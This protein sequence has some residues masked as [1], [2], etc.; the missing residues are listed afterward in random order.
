[1][2]KTHWFLTLSLGFFLSMGTATKAE[3]DDMGKLKKVFS[4]IMSYHNQYTQEKVY[5][6]L[7][8][9]GY[10]PGETIWFKA[11]VVGAGSLLPTDMSKVLYVE[12]LTPDGEVLKR[13]KYAILNGRTCGEFH[14]NNIIHTGYYEVRA[15]TR[16][17]LNWDPAYVFSRVI[18]VFNP[19]KE[20]LSYGKL[21]MYEPRDENDRAFKRPA[22]T[23]LR[24]TATQSADKVLMTFYPE[25]GYITQGVASRVAFKVTDKGGNP[26]STKVSLRR[27][28]DTEV[29]TTETVHEGMGV[30]NVPA[31]W[32]GG[33][34]LVEN[35]S[36][37]QVKFRLPA[38]RQTG[39]DIS[40]MVNENGDLVIKGKSNASFTSQT[41]GISVVC[42]GIACYFDTLQMAPSAAFEKKV[43]YKQLRG[44]IQQV[45][46]F[47]PQG[48][49]LSERL[50]WIEPHKAPM[51]FVVAQNASTYEPFSPI[52]LDF[53][54]KDAQGHP[55]QGEFS[56]AV[57]DIEGE[58]GADGT[59]INTELLL[60]SDLK[61]YIHKPEYYFE[62]NDE[63]HRQALDLLMMVQGWRRYAWKEMSGVEPFVLKQPVEDGL[64]VDGRIV[65][66]SSK[67]KGKEGMDVNLMIMLGGT[68]V[69]G[70]TKSAAD[71]SFALL[72]PDFYGDGVAYFTA[73]VNDKR[74]SCNVAL[75]RG[76]SPAP[77]PYHP[78]AM[79]TDLPTYK[80][81]LARIEPE[82]FQWTDTLPKI[83]HLP[84]ASVKEKQLFHP[85]GSRF[86]WMG[87][88]EAGKRRASLYYNI[89][90]ALDK[91]LDSGEQEMS[92]WDWLAKV[93]P[94]LTVEIPTITPK[95]S[96][97]GGD[98]NPDLTNTHPDPNDYL[99][100]N[101]ILWYR[102]C[103]VKVLLDNTRPIGDI[104]FMMSDVRSL[105][106]CED[107]NTYKN[108]T[109]DMSFSDDGR[110]FV[111]IL[112]YSRVDRGL[113]KDRKG[114]RVTVIHGYSK[115]EEFY[116]PDY[117]TADSPS[118][119][120][121][122][123]TLYWNPNVTTDKNGKAHVILFSNSR[124]NQHIRVNAQGMA[125][126]GQMFS[127]K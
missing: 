108:L 8:N 7:D 120:D 41:L 97:P 1:M 49:I 82:L 24:E 93:N 4:N 87:G 35:T 71:G 72:A 76:F 114:Q 92:L 66:N 31:D 42:R 124:P 44:G 13:N 34:A 11:Y 21:T 58:L 3:V 121:V 64:L 94:H 80:N 109:G 5:L 85:W 78:L 26:L 117:R 16:A 32:N 48:E 29:C 118:P 2:K 56:L 77:S 27:D 95:T 70:D 122:R 99:I 65:D 69:S 112:L 73:T 102:G 106:I 15:Y 6:H 60:C 79:K 12:L 125:I 68:F 63:T 30:L 116:N 39:C 45:T 51:E 14:L 115:Y 111:T 90:D 57:H 62:A 86:T 36:G 74:K 101:P 10:F 38:A 50:V 113:L 103:K 61:G 100:P 119:E 25:G 43:P 52:V 47:T 67:H 84:E 127:S 104:D 54:L 46:V 123:R 40:T 23:P 89:E 96:F 22:A 75:N 105:V 9:N 53:T 37:K 19:P 17:M 98:S 55:Q 59:D 88:E 126:T 18:P 107:L 33:Y 81:E 91:L 110:P 83:I 20:S 28:N